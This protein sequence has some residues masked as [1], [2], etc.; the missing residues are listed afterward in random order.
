MYIGSGQVHQDQ[1]TEL[2]ERHDLTIDRII[3]TPTA[4][5]PLE[6]NDSMEKGHKVLSCRTSVRS[7]P[8]A[9]IPDI[10]LHLKVLFSL[11][12]KLHVRVDRIE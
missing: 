5:F 8:D 2:L 9:K 10:K 4:S 1:I 12:Q 6:G 7:M 11:C 3:T